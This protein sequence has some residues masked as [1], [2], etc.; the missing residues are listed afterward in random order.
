[1]ITPRFLSGILARILSLGSAIALL[2]GCA[3]YQVGAIK[4]T[5]MAEVQTIAVPSF[6]NDTLMPRIE[7]QLA[8][9]VIKQLQQDGT[10]KIGR[11]NEADAILEG[12][13]EEVERRPLRSVPGNVLLTREYELIL[14]IRYRVINR[15]TGEQIEGR[16]VTGRTSFFVSGTN[17]LAADVVQDE[18]QAM[19]LAIE[20]AA[21]RLVSQIS[22]GW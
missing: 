15:V 13:L 16:A 19:P 21:V 3:G 6:K 5:P 4:P 12:V 17:A 1:M 2:G 18:I 10:Y 22:E 11:E 7:V 9:A 8:S 20:D 14:R